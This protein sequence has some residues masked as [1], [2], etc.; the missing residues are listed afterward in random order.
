MTDITQLIL[1]LALPWGV[2]HVNED[3]DKLHAKAQLLVEPF[4]D[5]EASAR[6]AG[7]VQNAAGCWEDPKVGEDG[8]DAVLDLA[9][10]EGF[11]L[12]E[13]GRPTKF[14]VVNSLQYGVLQTLGHRDYETPARAAGWEI[15]AGFRNYVTS[16][17]EPSIMHHDP[18]FNDSSYPA[19]A[20]G[21]KECCEENE[22]VPLQLPFR[23]DRNFDGLIVWAKP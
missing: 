21:W 17:G 2:D 18:S 10:I 22:I 1:T 7:F 6:A 8:M 15:R 19:D 4:Y 14:E 3:M 16:P 5:Y 23:I 20:E 9:E 12:I 13:I 11:D